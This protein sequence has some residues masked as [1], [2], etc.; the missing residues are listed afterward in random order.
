[1][2]SWGGGYIP[3]CTIHVSKWLLYWK[4]KFKITAVFEVNP[5]TETH[6][7]REPVCLPVNFEGY[8]SI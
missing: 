3:Q 2:V 7:S 1:M 6:L 5:E 4:Q 8:D